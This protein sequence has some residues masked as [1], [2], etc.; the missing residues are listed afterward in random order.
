MP[1]VIT[2]RFSE[3]V[4]TPLEKAVRAFDVSGAT[5]DGDAYN[6]LIAYG[7]GP[8]SF[9][10]N[11][12]TLCVPPKG[13][14]V[15]PMAGKGIHRGTVNY[16]FGTYSGQIDPL[17]MPPQYQ[18]VE[19][20]ITE[21]AP[22][23][24]S[25]NL[26]CNSAGDPF[27]PAPTKLSRRLSIIISR[28]EAAY[29]FALA[30]QYFDAINSDTF[31]CF[32]KQVLPGQAN[33]K[34]VVQTQKMP[35]NARYVPLEYRIDFAPGFIQINSS[36]GGNPVQLWD[37]F[38]LRTADRGK[39]AFFNDGTANPP[40]IDFICTKQSGGTVF[41]KVSTDVFL[42]GQGRPFNLTAYFDPAGNTAGPNPNLPKGMTATPQQGGGAILS[43]QIRNALPFG[44]LN[45]F[46]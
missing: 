35:S 31:L 36:V 32:G 30:A 15:R 10:P 7:V 44:A 28:N 12:P 29:P 26:I 34:C 22:Y 43:Y 2:E 41:N 19:S 40:H 1:V 42:D 27:S 18:W 3:R 33:F 46:Y 24:V 39:R 11:D 17:R 21:P 9:H 16:L 25:G 13:L 20:S 4:L 45:L 8:G 5:D 37:G 23:D 38:A 14:E 6:K